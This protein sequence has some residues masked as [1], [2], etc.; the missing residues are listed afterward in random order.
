MSEYSPTNHYDN[1]KTKHTFSKY[2]LLVCFCKWLYILKR[3]WSLI[4][5]LSRKLLSLSVKCISSLNT[6]A[7]QI[8]SIH[9][10]HAPKTN[11]AVVFRW[12]SNKGQRQC[13]HANDACQPHF[14]DIVDR[15]SSCRR[16]IW[17]T[18][19]RTR[20]FSFITRF[21]QICGLNFPANIHTFL[22]ENG[23]LGEPYISF[24]F[25]K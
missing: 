20:L 3:V 11:G 17:P 5:T 10:V 21:T 23:W 12:D 6:E 8:C 9:V 16:H 14:D 4:L 19:P 25:P 18:E 22:E 24:I 1:I 15:F 2:V 7:V 13:I